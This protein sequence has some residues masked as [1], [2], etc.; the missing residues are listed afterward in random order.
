LRFEM[1][2]VAMCRRVSADLWNQSPSSQ[3]VQVEQ[4]EP[5]V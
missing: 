4:G 5:H 1:T 3:T 2:I